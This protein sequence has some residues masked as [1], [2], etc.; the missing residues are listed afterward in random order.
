MQA[1]PESF[2]DRIDPEYKPSPDYDTVRACRLVSKAWHDEITAIFLYTGKPLMVINPMTQLQQTKRWQSAVQEP[3]IILDTIKSGL[4][5]P[6]SLSPETCDL[7]LPPFRLHL[8]SA[9]FYQE[10][11]NLFI[12]S[13]WP[14]FER[15]IYELH[16]CLPADSTMR[17]YWPEMHLENLRR[18]KI[19]CTNET[20]SAHKIGGLSQLHNPFANGNYMYLIQ[21]ILHG[22]KS[23][24]SFTLHCYAPHFAPGLFRMLLPC[25]TEFLDV[26]LVKMTQA[27]FTDCLENGRDVN[28]INLRHLIIRSPVR[29]YRREDEIDA[30]YATFMLRKFASSVEQLELNVTGQEWDHIVWTMRRDYVYDP[31]QVEMTEPM[32]K[33]KSFSLHAGLWEV[34][35]TVNYQVL[36]PQLRNLKLTMIT[37]E[38]QIKSLYQSKS[39]TVERLRLSFVNEMPY[40]VVKGFVDSLPFLR[41]FDVTIKELNPGLHLC[42]QG[43]LRLRRLSVG[44]TFC[45]SEEGKELLVWAITGIPGEEQREIMN[46]EMTMLDAIKNFE[47]CSSLRNLEGSYFYI[48][49]SNLFR[50]ILK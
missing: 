8:P 48:L 50:N 7:P 16:L 32:R 39:T 22:A 18:I 44:Y 23:A 42:F 14:H 29:I 47:N 40:E 43:F 26:P 38:S 5:R 4:V 31:L 25:Y 34:C 19:K 28:C 33:L 11:E 1:S 3:E 49:S 37:R 21:Q 27:E 6:D 41:E 30:R 10:V 20:Q 15:Y 12:H 46:E 24:E 2:L 36:L 35:G 13:T 45:N 17:F 9:L